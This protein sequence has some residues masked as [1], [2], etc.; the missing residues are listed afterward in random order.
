MR[1]ACGRPAHQIR[2]EHGRD[3]G[4]H[5]GLKRTELCRNII[6]ARPAFNFQHA[7][8]Q[9]A[10]FCARTR[11]APTPT[12]LARH[13]SD[14]WYALSPRPLPP[15]LELAALPP[16]VP[17]THRTRCA[18]SREGQVRPDANLRGC[19][20][21]PR[22]PCN[23]ANHAFSNTKEHAVFPACVFRSSVAGAPFP[24]R[25]VR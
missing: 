1:P 21:P 4:L 18:G 2:H 25:R 6:Y 16:R 19:G 20:G 11:C 22:A 12:A 23:H 24:R 13:Y 14:L 10:S 5:R 15:R 9:G 8:L 17:V 3:C 7:L